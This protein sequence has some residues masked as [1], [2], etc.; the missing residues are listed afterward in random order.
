MTTWYVI[1][2]RCCSLLQDRS[3]ALPQL[4]PIERCFHCIQNEAHVNGQGRGKTWMAGR[5]D[6]R[7]A[8]G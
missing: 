8:Q 5:P 1:P 7:L 4:N 6:L 2:V 3:P